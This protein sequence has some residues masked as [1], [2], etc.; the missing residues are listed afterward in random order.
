MNTNIPNYTL[1][2]E[3]IFVSQN[4]IIFSGTDDTTKAPIVVKILNKEHPTPE[5]LA[6]FKHEY[7]ITKIFDSTENI[8]KT[9]NFFKHGN[10]YIMVLENITTTSLGEVLSQEKKISPAIFLDLAIQITETLESIHHHE[11]IHKDI[12]VNNIMCYFNERKIKIIDFGFSANLPRER[13]EIISPNVLEGTLSYISPEQTGR[14]NRGIDYRTDY[15]SLGVTFYQML[16]GELPFPSKDPMELVH[17]HIAVIPKSPYECD[18]SIP[19]P[20]SDIIM[21]LLEKTAE[22]RY[23]NAAGLIADLERCRE[24]LLSTGVIE[25]FEL[26]SNDIFNR[27]QIPE[28]LYGREEEVALLLETYERVMKGGIEFMLV[29]GYSGIGKSALVYEIHK[30]I[31]HRQG[32]FIWGKFDQF[33]H[34]IPYGAFTQAFNELIK[35]LLSEPEE[36][37][38]AFRK[39][40]MAAVGENGQIIL[41]LIPNLIAIIGEQPPVLELELTESLNRFGYVFQNFIKSIC[42]EKH[43][44][45]IFLDDLQWADLPSLKMIETLLTSPDCRYL[46]IIG[47][48]R[49]NEVSETHPLMITLEALKKLDITCETIAVAPLKFNAVNELIADTLHQSTENTRDLAE[50]CYEKTAGNPF[51]LIQLLHTLNKENLIAFDNDKSVWTWKL[52]KIK[53]KKISENIVDLMVDKIRELSPKAQKILQLASCIGTEFTLNILSKIDE[54]SQEELLIDIQEILK[55]GYVLAHGEAYK[56]NSFYFAHDRIQQASSLLLSEDEKKIIHIDLARILLK[57]TPPEK[58]DEVIFDIANHYNNGVEPTFHPSITEDEKNKIAEL[59][60]KAAKLAASASA[61]EPAL[62]Y[63]QETLKCINKTLWKSNYPLMLEI[64]NSATECA[65][66]NA[67]YDLVEQYSNEALKHTKNVFDELAIIKLKIFAAT[68]EEKQKETLDLAFDTL[69]RLG[70]KTPKNASTIDVLFLIMKVKYYQAGKSIPDLIN[71]PLMTDEAKKASIP[72]S[73][74]VYAAAYIFNPN[75]LPFLSCTNVILSLKYGNAKGSAYAYSLYGVIPCGILNDIETGYQFSK[76][77]LDLMEKMNDHEFKTKI[78]FANSFFTNHWKDKAQ[79]VAAIQID[80]FEKGCDIG[81]FEHSSYSLM[82]A[83]M[84]KYYYGTPLKEQLAIIEKY[85]PLVIKFKQGNPRNY[86]SIYYQ[87]VLNLLSDS[88]HPEI[89][90]GPGFDETVMVPLFLK[91]GDKHGLCS[92]NLNKAILAYHF[93]N[94]ELA[95]SSVKNGYLYLDA[96]VSTSAIPVFHMYEALT[97][98][99]LYPTSSS[100]EKLKIS[101]KIKSLLK[102]FHY[103]TKCAPHN[104]LQRTQLIMAEWAGV[105]GQNDEAA[106]LYD[107]AIATAK[108]N[109]II[110]EEAL[111]YELAAKFYLKQGRDLIAAVYMQEARHRYSLW[112]A[113]GKVAYLNKQYPHLLK[114]SQL[115]SAIYDNA[116]SKSALSTRLLNTDS[117]V[118]SVSSSIG[119]QNL[120]IQTILKS[121]Q[122][123]SST[124]VLE[125]LL[126]NLM[127]IV[128]ENAG[129]QKAYLLLNKDNQFFIEAECDVNENEVKVLQSIPIT[130]DILPKSII[131]YVIRSKESVVLDRA[132]ESKQFG[133]D[134]YVSKTNLKSV[135]CMSLVN[136]GIL[137]GVL[138]IEN[139]LIDG[140]FTADRIATLDLLSSEIVISINNARLYSQTKEL[141][142]RLIVLNRA[143]ERFVP[144]DFLDLLHKKSI[145]DVALGDHTQISMSVLF[146][147][148]RNFT[149]RSEKMT[150]QENFDFINS[151]LGVMVPIIK[152]HS[153]FVDKYIGDA[154]MAL[155]PRNADDAIKASIEMQQT[156]KEYNKQNPHQDPI[157]I[158][159]GINTG[160]LMLGTVGEPNRMA[161]TVISDTVN[162]ASRIES[163]T[164]TYQKPI[165]IAEDTYKKIKN[166]LMYNFEKIGQVQVKGKAKEITIYQVSTIIK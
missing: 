118:H 88:E 154:I 124:I 51:F 1:N 151:F 135:L 163:L 161:A 131:N 115:S 42:S 26:G 43:P 22:R 53:E 93:E 130:D 99:A 3:P 78:I 105:Q 56:A 127:R 66:L 112:G 40:V 13:A 140:A 34:N 145:M 103:W 150:P 144:E 100:F 132:N 121:S 65:C 37:I 39:S 149:T 113:Q 75:L 90:V 94:Y 137:S 58:L 83:S 46:F 138:Y 31:V 119:S 70:I 38:A 67:K 20:I 87:V 133:K 79:D 136:Q 7:E 162:I 81:D 97:L 33:R 2:E 143:Y 11:I 15:Y 71:L 17:S 160:L 41:E 101:Y 4:S 55:E 120:D 134:S 166:P 91:T 64:Y 128:V 49:S 59:N 139:N 95:R 74:F 111:A 158:G 148:I 48:Y 57:I 142:E 89:L 50:L 29:A 86:I 153:G 76:L 36:N 8:V 122:A 35:Q 27:F 63:I 141:N 32:Y 45:V 77:A 155:F 80:N 52:D 19:K 54:R 62:L 84:L 157:E 23:Q 117:S 72:I 18:S 12:N 5:E 85:L 114:K 147:D 159:I 102:K 9:Y 110:N 107:E 14:M 73:T 98:I 28:K 129:G 126:K 10:T 125:D 156:L 25:P 61:F 82:D 21:K 47:A 116:S 165:L 106:K 6:R 44:L 123:L 164:K 30:P 108:Q 60:L 24:Q 68:A 146:T 152:K 109:N 92:V 16:T 96:L 69:R 104:Q